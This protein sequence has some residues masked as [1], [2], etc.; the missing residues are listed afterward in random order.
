[1][2]AHDELRE[3]RLRIDGQATCKLS[4]SKRSWVVGPETVLGWIDAL[5]AKPEAGDRE[6]R[7]AEWRESAT[8]YLRGRLGPSAP[9]AGALRMIDDAVALMRE[10]GA[11]ADGELVAAAEA[12]IRERDISIGCD[13]SSKLNLPHL[14][15]RAAAEEAAEKR[16][17][18]ALAAVRVRGGKNAS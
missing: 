7:I 3:L 8:L 17:R 12:Y 1:M 16:L 2:T 14:E 13:E 10:G 4:F 6:K 9:P 18:S 15:R 5:L 11:P